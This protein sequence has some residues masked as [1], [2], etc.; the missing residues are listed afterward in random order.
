VFK[1]GPYMIVAVFLIG[2]GYALWLR[3]VKPEV[4]AE[5]GLTVMEDAHERS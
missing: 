1:V 5:I 4:Y 3:F 2:L